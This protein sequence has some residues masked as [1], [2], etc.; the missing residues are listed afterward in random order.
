MLTM[1]S[2]DMVLKTAPL[3][4]LLTVCV[5][6]QP[7]F[8]LCRILPSFQITATPIS[9]R[10]QTAQS[11]PGSC[12][13]ANCSKTVLEC[14]ADGQ[15]FKASL[16]NAECSKKA[17]AEGCN[18]LCE[19]TYGYNS[20]KYRELLQC[21]SE[22]GCLPVSPPDGICLANDTDTVK[23]LTDIAQVCNFNI[24]KFAVLKMIMFLCVVS[25]LF[26]PS[27]D[28]IRALRQIVLIKLNVVKCN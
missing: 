3:L 28:L 14:L 24:F 8:I 12:L 20:S 18:L 2:C 11:G 17:N 16:C 10:G 25:T 19:L 22:H 27:F 7:A 26:V 6:L 9:V 21:M 4:I 23:N 5:V 15:C 13:V 1:S